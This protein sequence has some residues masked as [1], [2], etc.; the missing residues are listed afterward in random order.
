MTGDQPLNKIGVLTSGGDAQGMNAAVRAAA[1]RILG[2]VQS[3]W[4]LDKA[5]AQ[6]QAGSA[7]EPRAWRLVTF[8]CAEGAAGF[9]STDGF[10]SP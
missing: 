1:D 9:F 5:T 10:T 2:L 3:G 4:P 7:L 8:V 6:V